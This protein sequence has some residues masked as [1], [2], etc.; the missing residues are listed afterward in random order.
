[1]NN[2]FVFVAPMYNASKT[3]PQMLHSIFGQS[4]T[5]WSIVLTDDVSDTDD[6][7]ETMTV[8]ESFYDLLGR[9]DQHRLKFRGNVR[10]K[11]EVENVLTMI[12][13]ECLESDIVCRIDADDYLCDLDALRVLNEAYNQYEPDCIWT[14]HRWFDDKQITSFNISAQL[15]DNADPY[16]HPWVTSHLKTF[17]KGKFDLINDLNFR[18][19][20][21]NYIKRAGDQSLFLPILHNARKRMYLPMV[22]YAYRCDMNQANF[23]TEDAKFQKTEAEFIRARGYVA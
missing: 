5:N 4:Y 11:W 23:Q 21:G 8:I 22:T 18:G 6:L 17:R 1:M 19:S 7:V 16:K 10:K 2:R 20:D 3:L 15:P 9:N 14:A 12:K 13:D